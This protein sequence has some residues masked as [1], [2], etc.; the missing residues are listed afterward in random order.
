[1]GTAS[2]ALVSQLAEDT[3]SDPACWG[4]DSLRGHGDRGDCRFVAPGCDPG[5]S[6]RASRVRLPSITLAP[7]TTCPRG[8]TEK[9][10]A[11]YAAECRFDS[12]RG[13]APQ[14]WL[15]SSVVEHP[16]V[17]RKV[18]GS[19]P[20]GVAQHPAGVAQWQSP[21]LPNWPRRSDSGHPLAVGST[22]GRRRPGS[23]A[24]GAPGSA[25]PLHGRGSRF[26]SDLVHVS[27]RTRV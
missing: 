24:C 11:S 13:H 3:G 21:S 26:D 19:I 8:P 15:R 17:E 7:S 10:A 1:M 22:P 5:W 2:L 27:Q 23:W 12:C 9:A 4:F 6:V 14:S 25:L 20:V 16:P 18:A